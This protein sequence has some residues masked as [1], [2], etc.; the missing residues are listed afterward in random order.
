[1]ATEPR[2]KADW[3]NS[4]AAGKPGDAAGAEDKSTPFSREVAATRERHAGERD[5]MHKRHDKEF[6]ALLQRDDL[7]SAGVPTPGGKSPSPPVGG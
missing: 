1:M 4:E 2:K 5:D 3:Y 6:G 7:L